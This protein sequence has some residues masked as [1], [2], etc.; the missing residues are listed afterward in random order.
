MSL[1]VRKINI[2]K[3]HQVDL[4]STND[5]SAD[6]IT[7]CMKTTKNTLSVWQ[8]QSE[9]DLDKAVLALVANQDHLDK[10]DVVILEES[11]LLN[12][13][14]NILATPGDTPIPSLANTHRDIADLNYSK[15]GDGKNHIVDK[16]RAKSH[17]RYTVGN[18]K[19]LLKDAIEMGVLEKEDLKVSVKSKI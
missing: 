14:L 13:N 11:T 8:I 6:A 3:W 18:L 7:N 10:I 9:Q 17:K 19:K 1:L 5:V 16:I 2:A 4:S 15:I 12:Y